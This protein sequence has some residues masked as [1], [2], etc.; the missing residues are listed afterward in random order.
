MIKVYYREA[1][2]SQVGT[3]I[4]KIGASGETLELTY[5]G[6]RREIDLSVMKAGDV[7]FLTLVN[8]LEAKE[9]RF[10][11]ML[12]NVNK[13]SYMRPLARDCTNVA[14]VVKEQSGDFGVFLFGW[15]DGL[16]LWEGVAGQKLNPALP[17]I[18]NIYDNSPAYQKR[19]DAYIPK[20]TFL[21]DVSLYDNMA[22][23]ETQV[24]MLTEALLDIM[25]KGHKYYRLLKL[26]SENA[27]TQ[28]A[29]EE[30]IAAKVYGDKKKFRDRQKKYLQEKQRRG[31]GYSLQDPVEAPPPPTEQ[32]VQEAAR[33]HYDFVVKSH[34]DAWAQ[35]RN[36][37][38]IDSLVLYANENEPNETYKKEGA[39]GVVLKSLTWQKCYEIMGEVL[40]GQRAVPTEE[41]LLAELPALAWGDEE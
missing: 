2:A 22:Y 14:I 36:Y 41:E 40:A 5:D 15:M 3:G 23:L 21:Y 32:E 4:E 13:E 26:A 31:I 8:R 11:R 29:T 24:D 27:G 6:V 33:A 28:A 34:L 17:I 35:E 20:G 9:V 25:P 1:D 18:R 12:E 39:R 7:Y 19:F 10:F 30:S 37:D 38:S 16:Y